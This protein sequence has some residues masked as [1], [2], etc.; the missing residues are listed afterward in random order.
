MKAWLRQHR[1]ALKDAFKRVGNAPVSFLFN[2]LVIA[3]A[4]VLPFAGL[5]ILES[6]RPL[7]EQLTIE[8]EISVFLRP[9]LTRAKATEIAPTLRQL[10]KQHN[11][12][13]KIEFIEREKALDRLKGTTELVEAVS[14]L[15]A[16]PLPDAY[17]VKLAGF[18]NTSNAAALNGLSSRL[19]TV[20][21]VEHVQVDSSWIQRLAAF[22]SLAKLGLLILSVTLGT[23][24]MAVVFNTIRL[25]M[26]THAE[27]IEVSR[28]VGATNSYLYRPFYYSGALLG[29]GAGIVSFL[30][31][32]AALG[33]VNQAIAD[34]SSLY[35]SAFQLS[36]PSIW[37]ISA[38][39]GSSSLL[40]LFAAV[41]CTRHYLARI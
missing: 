18:Y 17:T 32:Y 5:T 30:V 41:I 14:A 38:L 7:S 39:L 16:N 10:L 13:G 29:M 26:L 25:Q 27:E 22:L 19:R 21:G 9:D 12:N 28:L 31:V 1:F 20:P 11:M 8:P 3:S 33:P 40:G 24:V 2:V 4:L 6:V 36:A 15:G 23:I 34:F 35:G 37:A